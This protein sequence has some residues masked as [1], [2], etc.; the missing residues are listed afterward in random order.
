VIAGKT[1][2]VTRRTAHRQLLLRPSER[3]NEIVG[4]ILAV[5]VERTGVL[6]HTAVVMSNH[7]HLLVTDPSARLPEF[8]QYFDGLVA[9]AMNASLGR[10]ESFWAPGSFSAVS[11][12][13]PEGVVEKAAYALANPVAAGLVARGKE[14]PGLWSPLEAVGKKKWRTFKRPEHFFSAKGQMPGT[15]SL[16]L[17]PPPGFKAEELRARVSAR[18]AELEKAASEKL[19]AE[20]RRFMGARK[21]LAQKPTAYPA[22]GEPRRELNPRVAAR[23]KWKRVEA[24]RRL[25]S[26]LVEYRIAF[27]KLRTGVKDAV[28]PHGTYGPRVVLGVACCPAG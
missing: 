12:E 4:Y 18:L 9:R 28:F 5:A 21:V 23:D 7:L 3:T 19:E 25:K 27:E 2:L 8:L 17:S 24:L 15:A 1:Y 22:P 6:L 14:W 11:L 26:F 10:W 16:A 13:G 20:S